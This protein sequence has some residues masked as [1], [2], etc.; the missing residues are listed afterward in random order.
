MSLWFRD[1][2]NRLHYHLTVLYCITSR[3]ELSCKN[4]SLVGREIP[5]TLTQKIDQESLDKTRM[6]GQESLVIAADI[7]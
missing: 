7:S 6:S 1:N 5:A 4:D 2:Y 3:F